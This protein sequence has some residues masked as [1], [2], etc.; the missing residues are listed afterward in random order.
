M[1]KSPRYIQIREFINNK[2]SSNVWPVGS[3]IPTEM[4]LTEQFGVSRM[5]VNK[6]IR[7]LVTAGLLKRTARVGTFV[8]QNKMESPLIDIRNIADEIRQRG[9][10]YSSQVLTQLTLHA[11]PQ[12]AIRLGVPLDT[13]IYFS[14][15]VHLEDD[16]PLQLEMRWVNP[17]F[18][19]DYI[20]QDFNRSTPN[21]YLTKNC[22]LSS[23]EHS[24][25]AVMVNKRIQGYLH[26]STHQPCLLLNRR[27]WSKQN[28]ISVALLYH[29]ADK[30]KLS[31]KT[32]L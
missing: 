9:K 5:T 25:E 26:L 32:N 30:Y 4:V 15:I 24:V 2:I 16:S 31:L 19:P 10:Q 8:C 20:K 23:I 27:T 29:P 11:D 28:L 18:A 3:K 12:T 22:P 7:D 1:D 13:P 14:E 6:A 21:E 17:S